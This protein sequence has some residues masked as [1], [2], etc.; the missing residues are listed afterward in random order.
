MIISKRIAVALVAV[1]VLAS[2]APEASACGRGRLRG[3]FKRVLRPVK[4]AANVV[5]QTGGGC[6]NGQCHAK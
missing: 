1:M 5:K 2:F 6:A 3:V 4:A